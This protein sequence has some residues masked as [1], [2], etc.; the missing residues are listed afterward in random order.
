M[1]HIYKFFHKMISP[2]N[3]VLQWEYIAHVQIIW[4]CIY[5]VAID[6]KYEWN[7]GLVLFADK[8]SQGYLNIFCSF[9]TSFCDFLFLIQDF[10][11]ICFSHIFFL[12]QI[13]F[14]FVFFI[15]SF[16]FRIF[17]TF[18]FFSYFLSHKGLSIYLF[19]FIFSFLFRIFP[20]FFFS[21]SLFGLGFSWYIF[22]SHSFSCLEFSRYFLFRYCLLDCGSL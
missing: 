10:C 13:F 8:N 15:F 17:L 11:H 5:K 20:I 16:W 12:A 14:I 18:V 21:Y 4:C 9:Y 1:Y 2:D 22:F 3:T 19:F 7:K 6:W